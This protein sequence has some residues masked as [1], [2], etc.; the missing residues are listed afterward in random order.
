M[1]TAPTVSEEKIREIGTYTGVR[2]NV[3]NSVRTL[4]RLIIVSMN[5]KCEEKC[6]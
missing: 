2:R 4:N 3:G 5:K 1:S 6:Q